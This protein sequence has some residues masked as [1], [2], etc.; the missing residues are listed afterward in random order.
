MYIERNSY[1]T[2]N[3]FE[4][5]VREETAHLA[6]IKSIKYKLIAF[7]ETLQKL[8]QEWQKSPALGPG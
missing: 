4:K 6:T 5:C 1:S 3:R 8:E 7:L 2:R